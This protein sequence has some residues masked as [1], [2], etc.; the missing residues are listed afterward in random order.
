MHIAIILL[1]GIAVAGT[2]WY[3]QPRNRIKRQLR[4]ARALRIAEL[5]DGQAGRVIGR[6][7]VLEQ[8]LEAPLSGRACVFYIARVEERRSSGKHS[9]WRTI[10]S[11]QHGVPFVLEDDSGYA[12]VDATAAQIALDFDA[13]SSSGTFDDPTP[14]ETAFLERH[15]RSGTGWFFNRTLRYREAVIGEGETI[16]VL[17]AGTREPDP[18]AAPTAAYRG[19]PPTRLRLTSSPRYPLVISDDP[20]TTR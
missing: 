11:E 8:T 1:V 6:A 9:Y 2:V 12:I 15:G 7:R 3:F 18:A 19:E 17:G 10:I 14:A 13:R 4:G 5:G 20:D 16:A